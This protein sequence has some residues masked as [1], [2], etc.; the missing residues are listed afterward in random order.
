MVIIDSGILEI[1]GI[2]CAFVHTVENLVVVGKVLFMGTYG[3][4]IGGDKERFLLSVHMMGKLTIVREI[5][6]G[7]I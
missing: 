7:R 4:E 1:A 2:S 5:L 6:C 3:E